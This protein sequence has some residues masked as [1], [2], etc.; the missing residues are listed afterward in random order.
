MSIDHLI[1]CASDIC[2]ILRVPESLDVN[3]L[4]LVNNEY[5]GPI[6]DNTNFK[7]ESWWIDHTPTS[8]HAIRD[9]V[10]DCIRTGVLGFFNTLRECSDELV[11]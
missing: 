11:F 3:K 6:Y 1:G 4:R 9:A 7:I 8:K 2:I 10:R 5:M